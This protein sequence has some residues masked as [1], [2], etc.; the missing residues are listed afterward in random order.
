[1]Q[2]R[3]E[4][5]H[6]AVVGAKNSGKS[7]LFT[8]LTGSGAHVGNY[9]GVTTHVE[10]CKLVPKLARIAGA[11][12]TVLDMPG[13]SSLTAY[14]A[15]EEEALACLLDGEIE[16]LV[17]V[18]DAGNIEM[19][20]Y[21]S[22]QLLEL[23]IPTVI[24]LNMM[25]EAAANGV[26]VDTALLA[27]ELRV[28]V[29]PISAAKEQGITSLMEA[30]AGQLGTAVA[31]R[32]RVDFCSGDLHKAL[33]SICH[34]LE[35]PAREQGIP[36]RYAAA[37]FISH[38]ER[39]ARQL[40][41]EPEDRH[42]IAEIIA[43]LEKDA[44]MSGE[45]VLATERY[46]FVDGLCARCVHRRSRSREQERSDKLDS[47]LTHRIWGIP[48]FLCVIALVFWLT[49]NAV[50]GPLQGLLE[51][52]FERFGQLVG[53]A[54]L[55]AGVSHWLYDLLV[56]GV[57]AG[58]CSV[59]SFLPI[60]MV[61]F[62]LLSFLEDS[63][64]MTR[65]AYIMDKLLR[66]VGLSGRSFAPL[67]VGFGCNVPAIISTR[68]LPSERD[69][70]LTVILTPFMSC[71]AKLPVYAMMTAAF[72]GSSAGL[73][74]VSLYVLGIAVAVC[75]SLLLSKTLFK[76]D[77]MMYVMELPSY[78]VPA[79][80]DVCRHMWINAA[81][82]VK[83][84]FTIIFVGTVVIWFMQNFDP[85][86]NPVDDA[87]NS[88]L[89]VIGT[90]LAPLLAPIGLDSWQ[91][92]TGLLAGLAAKEAIV[93]TLAVLTGGAGAGALA[94]IFTPLTAYVFLVFILLYVP[95]LATFA[96]TRKELGS[97]WQALLC[98]AS[99]IAIAYAVCFC[100]YHLGLLF[101]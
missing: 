79:L 64:Y 81:E 15:E 29:I 82:F 33:H 41:G 97:T 37:K 57:I 59:L 5:Q 40:D 35:V 78:R 24:A 51:S 12:A 25:D 87:G 6:I 96:T 31:P 52:L 74:M 68:S 48:I 91:A 76:G 32:S 98:V 75:L 3:S 85:S 34:T 80:R 70:K 45:V 63:G 60:I 71:S 22:L 53:E 77:A 11:S 42:I 49:F 55:S 17:N 26:S 1:M 86:F 20:L 27:R 4:E 10:A 19:G 23:N 69:R 18:V 8:V 9:P 99:Q 54:L 47:L 14:S 58:V 93:S 65:A 50:G 73:V 94:G 89:A 61:L 36:L 84:A 100:I 67:I 2:R 95:C 13:L 62:F 21:L 30:V 83:K 56:N 90:W 72:F 43:H 66:K 38:D 16:L 101:V 28:P 46:R 39:I 88:I 7:A 92:T 44:G